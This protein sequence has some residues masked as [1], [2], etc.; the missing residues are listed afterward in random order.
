MLALWKG[1]GEKIMLRDDI[2]ILRL[3]NLENLIQENTKCIFTLIEASEYLGISKS[4]LYKLTSQ[5]KIPFH[6]PNGKL[7][8]FQKSDLDNWALKNRNKP[9]NEIEHDSLK[10]YVDHRLNQE[11]KISVRNKKSINHHD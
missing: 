2:I 6:K 1:K 4:T 9:L 3:R 7:I 10:D 8:Y 5:R 11:K